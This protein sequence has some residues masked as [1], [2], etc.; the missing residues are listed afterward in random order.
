MP[1]LYQSLAAL[2]LA[3]AAGCAGTRH[4]ASLPE[5]NLQIRSSLSGAKAVMGVHRLDSKCAAEYEGAVELDQPV[6]QVGLPPGR[7]SL[8]VFE[9][10]GSSFLSGSNSI[11]K[12]VDHT[13]RPGYRYEARVR[14]KDALYG[15]EVFEIDPRSGAARDLDSRR[16]C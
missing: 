2:A 8:L 16:R 5:K 1:R 15:V 11:K 9:F 3:L 10:Y 7:P 12:E 13:P 14:Y 4:Y 6:V